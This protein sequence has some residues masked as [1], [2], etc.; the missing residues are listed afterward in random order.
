MYELTDSMIKEPLKTNNLFSDNQIKEGNAE[1]NPTI[2]APKPMDTRRAGSAQQ[3]NV[4]I[5]VKRPKNE[6][7]I[8][9]C[10]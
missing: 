2:V 5:E 7:Q 4:L 8:L 10:N 9:F 1:T 3:T 6:T